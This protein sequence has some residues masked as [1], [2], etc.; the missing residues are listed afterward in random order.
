T[1]RYRPGGK[2]LD[3]GCAYGFFLPEAR[4]NFDVSR[5]EPAPAAAAHC[6]QQG[7]NV[8]TGVADEASLDNLGKMDVIVLLD[9]IEH[10]PEPYET[11]ALC[12]RH[13]N[14]D[15]VILLTTG[16]FGSPLARWMGASWRL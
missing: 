3:V 11:L 5:I 10:L 7:L 16:D 4:R 15:G 12:A 8:L 2:L 14:P 6:R 9:V 1:R 13:L